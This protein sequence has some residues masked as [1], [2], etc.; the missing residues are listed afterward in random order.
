MMKCRRH[1]LSKKLASGTALAVV[2]FCSFHHIQNGIFGGA[3]V[4]V[5]IEVIYISVNGIIL[6]VLN[7]YGIGILEY[8]QFRVIKRVEIINKTNISLQK[9]LLLIQ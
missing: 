1:G 7:H 9:A 2:L 3:L 6:A 8:E 5:S 4:N